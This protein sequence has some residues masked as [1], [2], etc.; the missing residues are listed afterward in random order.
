MP[1]SPIDDILEAARA[2][3][4]QRRNDAAERVAR[5]KA[6][7]DAYLAATE[8]DLAAQFASRVGL[9]AKHTSQTV[10]AALDLRA[11]VDA[12]PE[13]HIRETPVWS[14]PP[15]RASLPPDP[16]VRA[17]RESSPDSLINPATEE[18]LREV[19]AANLDEMPSDLFRVH[20]EEF[21]AR[22]R[23]LQQLFSERVTDVDAL[24][25]VIRTLTAMVSK[26]GLTGIYGLSRSHTGD[27]Q[28]RAEEAARKKH[29]LLS[30]PPH[31]PSDPDRGVETIGEAT[32]TNNEVEA[33][34]DDATADAASEAPIEL[35]HLSRSMEAGP[36]VIVGGVVK[37][38]KLD[39]L[40]R[41]TGLPVEWVPVE[42]GGTQAIGSLER[43]IRG[44]R[45][46]ALVVL[47]DLM[48]H[49]HFEPLV[50]AARQV[51]M[52][53][54]FGGKAG[55]ASIEKALADLDAMM[56]QRTSEAGV[57]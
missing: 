14:Q 13:V 53:W 39:R 46:A 17:A 48:G 57:G 41:R 50:V 8:Q 27:W 35:S 25:R 56:A 11:A 3:L 2:A 24:G 19:R 49:K 16:D 15:P 44:G 32:D 26:R 42:H 30:I 12:V 37:A 10:R 40:R 9:E 36:V 31:A 23:H 28:A 29:R 21:A 54:V 7:A 55:K 5:I 43:R 6:A 34:D 1:G 4:M 52:P 51:G 47:Q 18:L 22:A 33:S 45:I 20:A 38:D